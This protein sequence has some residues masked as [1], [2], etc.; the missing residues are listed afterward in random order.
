MTEVFR[1]AWLLNGVRE[2]TA[3]VVP[4]HTLRVEALPDQRTGR[5]LPGLL[6]EVLADLGWVS[7]IP[8]PS[9]IAMSARHL[10][11]LVLDE[12][13]G[14]VVAATPW[15]H[16][17]AQRALDVL[18][19][20]GYA[21]APEIIAGA[22]EFCPAPGAPWQLLEVLTP[23]RP[24]ADDAL[25]RMLPDGV[26]LPHI[27]ATRL[28]RA[29]DADPRLGLWLSVHHGIAAEPRREVRV[30]RLCALV[31]TIGKE[32]LKVT[33]RVRH[34]DGTPAVDERGKQ[35]TAKY[36]RGRLAC[37]FTD[38]CQALSLPEAV[39]C[40]RLRGTRASTASSVTLWDESRVWVDWRN[41]VAHEGLLR[42]QPLSTSDP[43]GRD[44]VV[45]AAMASVAPNG[46]R[47]E[48]LDRY[49]DTLAAGVVAVLLAA[50]VEVTP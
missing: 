45:A 48:G 33:D 3:I 20:A 22:T 39:L 29:A 46:T 18:S 11:V 35:A 5:D 31:E 41:R 50:A 49:A 19:V 23:H 10:A 14:D 13:H 37:L 25:R 16:A 36:L 32:T 15:L 38:A 1:A 2:D 27:D 17:L 8:A 47:D 43:L 24:P 21:A 6:T 9:F 34:F 44:R 7:Q 42:P 28:W 4:P 30:L 12:T 40:P 26:T